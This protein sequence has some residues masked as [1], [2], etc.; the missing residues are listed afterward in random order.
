M[1]C[2]NVLWPVCLVKC[3]SA[4]ISPFTGFSKNLT[5]VNSEDLM[6]MASIIVILYHVPIS[7]LAVVCLPLVHVY[8]PCACQLSYRQECQDPVWLVESLRRSSGIC[9]YELIIERVCVVIFH[10]WYCLLI[11]W[12]MVWNFSVTQ[13]QYFYCV[14]FFFV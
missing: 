10:Y 5:L 1:K 4:M 14:I 2:S 9:V 3:K 11:L 7:S 13:F 8:L 6:Y 12:Q